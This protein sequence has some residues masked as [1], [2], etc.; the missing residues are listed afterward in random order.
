MDY[1]ALA[2]NSPPLRVLVVDDDED[3]FVLIRQLC[4]DISGRRYEVRWTATYAAA[5]HEIA[6]VDYDIH[7]I[8]FGLAN[9]ADW[10]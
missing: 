6:N 10:I 2:D 7:L 1:S 4:T 9:R 3:D 5:L 8:D